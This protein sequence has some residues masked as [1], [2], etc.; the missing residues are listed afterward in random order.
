LCSVQRNLWDTKL[1]ANPN[2]VPDGLYKE[3]GLSWSTKYLSVLK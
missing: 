2:Y 3:N 1:K